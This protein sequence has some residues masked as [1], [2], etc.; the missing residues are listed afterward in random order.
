MQLDDPYYSWL[1]L[2]F[3]LIACLSDFLDGFLARKLEIESN[4]GRFLDPIAD[5]ILV[6]TMLIILLDN[7]KISDREKYLLSHKIETLKNISQ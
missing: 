3:Y 1:G 5:K 7:D 4:F 2:V 6:V